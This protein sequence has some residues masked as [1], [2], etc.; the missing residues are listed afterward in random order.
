L[1]A[2]PKF[3]FHGSLVSGASSGSHGVGRRFEGFETEFRDSNASA[4]RATVSCAGFEFGAC[5]PVVSH[6][7]FS[8]LRS[9]QRNPGLGVW[10]CQDF[11]IVRAF[12]RNISSESDSDENGIAVWLDGS[13]LTGRIADSDFIGVLPGGGAVV[14]F[15]M[16]GKRVEVAGCTFGCSQTMATNGHHGLVIEMSNQFDVIDQSAQAPEVG[17]GFPSEMAEGRGHRL[18]YIACAA[19]VASAL[20]LEVLAETVCRPGR[21][22]RPPNALPGRPVF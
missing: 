21:T 11:V 18:A 6:C 20:L 14:L 13:L 8:D 1:L 2:P 19:L 7:V 16:D 12:F 3:T 4:I 9:L 10:Q 22:G 15:M 5:T 17:A